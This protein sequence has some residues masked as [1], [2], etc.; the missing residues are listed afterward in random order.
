VTFDVNFDHRLD[1]NGKDPD[2]F[3]PTLK[4]QHLVLWSK[5]LPDGNMFE[6]FPEPSKYLVHRSSLG[7]FH[8]SSDTISHSLR[9][10]RKM[11]SIISQIPSQQL[12]ALQSAGNVIGARV[13]FPGNRIENR[14]TIN[15]ARGT[16]PKLND[17]FD[18]TLE[19]IRLHYLGLPNPIESVLNRYSD[20]FSLF[21][22]F[23][24]YVEFFLLDDLVSMDYSNVLFYLPHDPAFETSPKPDSID[25]YNKYQENTTR[26]IQ[27]RNQRIQSWVTE[28]K[29]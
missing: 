16:H 22:S 25:A 15:Q 9:K 17:R 23:R 1:S 7:T 4:A 6:L 18:L 3:S 28:N 13:L 26:F 8:L 11:Q 12:D 14:F 20:F 27:A 2:A 19:C 10:Q 5:P 24:N 21:G 29:S